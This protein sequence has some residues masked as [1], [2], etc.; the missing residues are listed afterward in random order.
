MV[1]EAMTPVPRFWPGLLLLVAC[2]GD[3]GAPSPTPAEPSAGPSLP[4]EGGTEGPTA[5]GAD[6]GAATPV[7]P[8]AAPA[9]E[10]RFRSEWIAEVPPPAVADLAGRA[11]ADRARLDEILDD[12][13][14]A[15][16][17][18]VKTMRG[19]LSLR[20]DDVALRLE[21]GEFYYRSELPN[22]AEVALLTVLELDPAQGV[23]HKLL[24]DVYRQA[25]DHGRATWHARRAHRDLPTDPTVMFL[26]GWTLRDGGDLEAAA[27]VAE[28]GLELDPEDDRVLVL[29]AMLR[30]D[31]G[32][33]EEAVDLARRGVAANPDHLRGHAVLGQALV[34][35]GFEEEGE[36]EMVLHRR[37]LL[38]N[39]AKLLRRDP[40]MP[41]WERA[42]ALA[43]YHHLVGRM[44]LARDELARSDV[45][46]PGNPAARVIEARMAVTEGD[47][48]RAFA[49]LEGLLAEDA[50]EPRARRAL[51]NL[52]VLATDPDRRDE[53]RALALAG[54]LLTQGG[55]EDF[56]VLF[57][58]GLA[59]L[60]LGYLTQAD[61]HLRA[62]LAIEPTNPFALEAM[63]EL[64][65]AKDAR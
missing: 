53:E 8:A 10:T 64:R 9:W 54:G 37:L 4:A 38:L 41:E 16:R 2:G 1:T 46:L 17:A 11:A 3:P 55:G 15:D 19:R 36:A 59:E 29:L 62:A 57:T 34:A 50:A 65:A 49:L 22:L 43:H 18:W 24:A 26:W 56:E 40:P 23:A 63:D 52:L 60:R 51:A 25:G 42:A 20:P 45:L 14:Q 27:A 58:V 35:L 21:L 5:N 33:Y 61:L 12:D 30:A 32:R 47:E 39:S 6:E 44:D 28:R 13:L 31:D 48:P 7:A